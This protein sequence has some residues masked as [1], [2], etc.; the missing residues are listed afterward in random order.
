MSREFRTTA[1]IALTL[2]SLTVAGCGRG[3]QQSSASGDVAT[4][5]STAAPGASAAR[6]TDSSAQPHHSKLAGAAVGALVGHELG[7]HAVAR[8]AAAA[9]V[10]P[11]RTKKS[12]C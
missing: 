8:R 9:L 4:P 2:A 6:A 12:H 5:S 7:G 10:Q 1:V 3:Q 11:P